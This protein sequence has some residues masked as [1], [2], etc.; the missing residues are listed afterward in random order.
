MRPV[1]QSRAD[2]PIGS[3]EITVRSTASTGIRR[4]SRARI[5]LAGA[6]MLLQTGCALQLLPVSPRITADDART[7]VTFL[8]SDKM[9]GRMTASRGI[10][11]AGKYIAQRLTDAGVTP[12]GDNGTFFR[13]FP[14]VGRA[15]EMWSE[16]SHPQTAVMN[17]C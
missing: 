8:A 3:L 2:R 12:A 15:A 1:L 17:T 13:H 14:T 16:C 10:R 4:W 9:E 7:H 11:R 5:A 6:A